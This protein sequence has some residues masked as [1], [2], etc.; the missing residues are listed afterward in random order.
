M[1][2]HIHL[3][4]FIDQTVY[5]AE[6][7]VLALDAQFE[8]HVQ[9]G[10]PRSAAAGADNAD[11]LEPL[12]CHEQRIGRGGPDN[13]GCTVLVVMENRNIHPLAA[14]LFHDE[15]IGRFDI[16]E[17]DG[18][19]GGFQRADDLGQFDRIGFV[20]LDIETVD[21]RKFLEQ[22]GLAFHHR[23]GGQRPDIAKAKHSRAVC[24]NG[25]QI[26]PRGIAAGIGGIVADFQ[27]GLGHAGRIGARQIPPVGKWL[28]R[29][30]FQL[31]G[32]GKFMIGQRRLSQRFLLTVGHVL[33][34]CFPDSLVLN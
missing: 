29:A 4:A 24:D 17:V 27:T 16:L 8:Q 25:H 34:P 18:A 14:K 7:D 3:A 6:P 20:Q 5:I 2:V 28:G 21:T 33:A 12:A 9:A 26:A 31:S 19:E 1:R 10:N 15:T 13:N 22:D 23:L 32:L 11:I 30:D